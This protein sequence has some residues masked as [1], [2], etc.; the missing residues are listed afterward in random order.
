GPI[1][2]G[3]GPRAAGPDPPAGD[4]GGAV[5]GPPRQRGNTATMIFGVAEIVGYVSRFMTLLPG[6]VICTGTPPGV[7]MGMKPAPQF[8]RDG[9]VMRLGI[10]GLGEQTLPVRG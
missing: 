9:D 10:A 3:G 7:G 8:L 6:D 4:L 2:P 5:T 1:A